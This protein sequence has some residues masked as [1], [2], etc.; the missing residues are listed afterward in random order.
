M[1]EV[2][3]IKDEDN[4]IL[5]VLQG[6]MANEPQIDC[7][8]NH[9]FTQGLYSR[10]ITMPAD[11]LIISKVHKTQHQFIVS[12]GVVD[13]YNIQ[14]GSCI[15]IEAPYSGITEAGTRRMLYVCEETIWTTFHPLDYLTSDI[16]D[17]QKM[18]DRIE[19]DII[20][21]RE[22]SNELLEGA[23]KLLNQEKED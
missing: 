8:L 9:R 6:A 19:S 1:D 7:P 13:V 5:D 10:E 21:P 17:E 14:D 2:Q 3:R 22:I 18:V 23:L 15:R 11:T 16:E 12:K 4:A 20:E